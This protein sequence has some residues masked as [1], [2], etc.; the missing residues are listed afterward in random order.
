MTLSS[1]LGIP[2]IFSS[3]SIPWLCSV[4]RTLLIPFLNSANRAAQQ[5]IKMINQK[6]YEKVPLGGSWKRAPDVLEMRR[7][8]VSCIKTQ[9]SLWIMASYSFIHPIDLLLYIT[10][11]CKEKKN[12]PCMIKARA[13]HKKVKILLN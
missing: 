12:H 8:D 1:K 3:L 10:L 11:K 9:L 4:D 2:E 13:K 6:G 7:E 5:V